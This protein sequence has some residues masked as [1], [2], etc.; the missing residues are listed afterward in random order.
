MQF[1][2][3]LLLTVASYGETQGIYTLPGRLSPIISNKPRVCETNTKTTQSADEIRN[4]IRDQVNPYLTSHYGPPCKCGL[5]WTKVAD[6]DMSKSN[7]TCPG[8]WKLVDD[9][10]VRGCG[11]S[12]ET[13]V[14]ALFSTGHPFSKVCGQVIAIQFGTP[15]AF[16]QGVTYNEGIE[17][18]YID[19]V[20]ISYGSP[21]S[22]KHIWSFV[23]ANSEQPSN[24]LERCRCSDTSRSWPF[25]I[26]LFIGNNYFCDSGQE[27][28]SYSLVYFSDDPLWDGQ[29]CGSTSNCC[30]VNSPPW[31]CTNITS[32]MSDDDIEV[33]ICGSQDISDEN[34]VVTKVELYVH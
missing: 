27:T 2:I 18:P 25:S 7:Q 4:V 12:S 10:A 5:R 6:L 13:C 15:D 17:G 22:R 33:R 34:I 3:I 28:H 23:A 8:D 11:R 20:S 19:G 32:S 29:G 31:F 21:G 1:Y 16:H 14:S 30:S 24:T 26:P 9:A